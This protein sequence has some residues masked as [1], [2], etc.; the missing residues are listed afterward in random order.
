MSV[1]AENKVVIFNYTLTNEQ[2]T[3]LDSSE[4]QTPMSYLHGAGNIIPGLERE[5][6]G[7]TPGDAFTAVVSPEDA[8]GEFNPEAFLQVPRAQLP[9]GI[10]FQEGLQLIA[11]DE[12]GGMMPIFMDGYDK[13][14]DI[15]TFNANHPLAGETL[16]FQVEV[17]DVQ[18][19]TEAEL[20][21][22]HPDER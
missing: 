14:T 16:T 18:D 17:V 15:F 5:M 4:G 22:G 2:G 21:Q 7:K 6:A 11:Q 10:E 19:A 13:E 9:E 1:I 3:V 8:Y 20:A 12:N